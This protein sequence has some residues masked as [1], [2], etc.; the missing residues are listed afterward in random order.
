MG[1]RWVK[2]CEDGPFEEFDVTFAVK[3]LEDPHELKSWR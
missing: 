3:E 2:E 1:L